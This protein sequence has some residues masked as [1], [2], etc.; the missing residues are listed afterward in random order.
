MMTNWNISEQAAALHRDAILCDMSKSWIIQHPRGD[1]RAESLQECVENGVDYVA[2]TLANDWQGMD[3][4][5]QTMANERAFVQ[6]NP[7]KYRFVETVDD[8]LTAK[9]EGTL[10]IGFGF[11][12]TQSLDNDVNMVGVYHKLGIRTML[13]AYNAKNS[14]GDG[15]M[16]ITDA[17]LT[18]FGVQVVQEMNR[19]GM[20][21]DGTH[22]GY[23]TTM[24]VMEVSTEPVIFSHSNA[25]GAWKHPRNIKDDQIKACAKT[26]GVIC[27]MGVGTFVGDNDD[28]AEGMVKH[29]DYISELVG[30]EHVGIGLDYVFDWP[31]NNPGTS[32]IFNP[33][34]AHKKA[35]EEAS[36][37]K[38]SVEWLDIKFVKPARLPEITDA[39]IKRGYSEAEIRGVLGE[40]WLRVARQVWK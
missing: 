18:H 5:L 17:G 26:G 40:N 7:D 39:M 1:V 23:R 37:G 35:T 6:A 20:L 11:Q 2:L 33:K 38:S 25:W 16:E 10:A 28:T 14:A 21:A 30:P 22:T 19:V 34:D 31:H 27:V 15:C 24:D 13:M 36:G 8:I 12:G 32:G 3:R 4:T 29:I 9:K